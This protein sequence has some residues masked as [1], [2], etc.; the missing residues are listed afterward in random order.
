L[1]NEECIIYNEGD[2]KNRLFVVQMLLLPK[3]DGINPK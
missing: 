3:Q 2:S 1:Y